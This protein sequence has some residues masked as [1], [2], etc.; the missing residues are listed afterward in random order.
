MNELAITV[1]VIL[2]PGLIA[3][4][5]A[6]ALIV[7]TKPWDSFR[8]SVYSFTFG[9]LSYVGLQIIVWIFGWL[10]FLNVTFLPSLAG[11]L[12][13]WNF[14]NPDKRIVD[15]TEVIAALLVGICASIVTVAIINTKVVIRAANKTRISRKY[16]DENLFSYFLN[17]DAVQWVYVRDI[18]NNI[19]YKGKV[20]SFSESE[21]VQ[22]LVLDDVTIYDYDSSEER[23]SVPTVY[24][25]KSFGKFII[26][27][28]KQVGS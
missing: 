28:I 10:N 2:F 3:T 1:A 12:D 11:K 19:T 7:H 20:N 13:I 24:L 27:Q 4:I 5:L 9:V 8:Y 25:S 22:E 18:D 15:V 21:N 23:Y 6:D 16:G 17:S 26:E 14:A